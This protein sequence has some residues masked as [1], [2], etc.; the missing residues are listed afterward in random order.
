[1]NATESKTSVAELLKALTHETSTLVRQEVQL[2]SAEIGQKVTRGAQDMGAVLLG[3]SI[4][5][6]GLLVLLG[7]AVVALLPWVSL[8][9][10]A[11]LVGGVALLSG[12]ALLMSGLASLKKLDVTPEETVKSLRQN[13]AWLKEQLR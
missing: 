11:L 10:A 4:A 7:A 9:M 3:G 1:M 12:G 5:H 6:A 13:K 2:A 8:L